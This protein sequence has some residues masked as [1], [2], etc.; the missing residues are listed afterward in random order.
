MNFCHEPRVRRWRTAAMAVV[1]L[2]LA[3]VSPEA[4]TAEESARGRL[5][6]GRA[7]LKSQNYAEALKDFQ[8]ILQAYPATSVADEALLEVAT[9]QLEVAFDAQAATTAVD[10]LLTQYANSDSVP[11]AHVVK[12][13][14]ALAYGFAPADVAAAIAEFD[15]V[16]RQ[17]PGNDAVPAAMYF[18][19]EAAR[20]GNRR[21]EAIDRFARVFT[22]YPGTVWSQ[23]AL[24]GSAA[25]LA[26][27]GEPFRAMEQL[28]RIRQQ[29]PGSSEAA[30][31]L[32]WNTILY[33]L[34]VRAPE[35]PPYVFANPLGGPS[36]RF[37]E[38]GDIAIDRD[39]NLLV[40]SRAGVTVLNPKGGLLRTIAVPEPQ[41][42]FFDG[43]GRAMTIHE[44]GRLREDGQPGLTLST[45]STEG[46]MRPLRLDAG[47]TT[48]N[49]D[50]L[51]SDRSLRS[52]VRFSADGKPKGEFARQIVARRLAITELDDVAALD[53]DTRS[54]T[55]LG[56]DGRVTAR[57]AE[58]GP[59]YQFREP[60]D[61]ALD[62]LGHLYVLDRAA[63][64]V[65]TQQQSPR[66]LATFA[67]PERAPGAFTAAQ[68]MALDTA[69]RLFVFDG[70]TDIVQVF[71]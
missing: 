9:Y 7:F 35:Q 68:A 53:P 8:V 14:L 3:T 41:G 23:R 19:A 47:V 50:L 61:V 1:A 4:Q 40:A 31:A 5:E 67:V 26:A 52:I 71:R 70:R 62:S 34:H 38:V 58:R 63:L 25:A 60:V 66:L 48:S 46:R 30:V 12:G 39:N 24:L 64:H 56:W 11:M 65:F 2:T 15:G 28:Q 57:I 27:G 21:D 59:G 54:V 18:S 13:R 20:R 32:E 49:G 37:R 22:Q 69:G 33:R 17:Y 42:I 36:G 43:G 45:V 29:F 51:V 55:L 16:A 44:G 10:T 6:S